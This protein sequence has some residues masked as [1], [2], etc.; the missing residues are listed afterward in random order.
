MVN[1]NWIRIFACEKVSNSMTFI[2]RKGEREKRKGGC[3]ECH[4]AL[5]NPLHYTIH[6][7]MPKRWYFNL[8]CFCKFNVQS[9]ESIHILIWSFFFD[10]CYCLCPQLLWITNV[11]L[12]LYVSSS[13]TEQN[14]H[15]TKR[16]VRV[17]F[18]DYL[19]CNRMWTGMKTLYTMKIDGKWEFSS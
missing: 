7:E 19:E 2:Y 3:L 10:T 5:R 17:K 18:F 9:N 11:Y 1:R 4:F 14:Q 6:N 12:Y 15:E 16:I 13:K 8:N